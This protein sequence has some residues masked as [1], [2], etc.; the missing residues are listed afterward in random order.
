MEET[1]ISNEFD[2]IAVNV[3]DRINKK[4]GLKSE[5]NKEKKIAVF[6]LAYGIVQVITYISWLIVGLLINHYTK[7]LSAFYVVPLSLLTAYFHIK[8]GWSRFK[9]KYNNND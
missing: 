4:K 7:E 3:V 1:I 8:I 6:A 2:K 9:R 5:S